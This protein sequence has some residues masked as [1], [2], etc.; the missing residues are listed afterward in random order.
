MSLVRQSGLVVAKGYRN[1]KRHSPDRS[2]WR[3]LGKKLFSALRVLYAVSDDMNCKQCGYKHLGPFGRSC[4]VYLDAVKKRHDL[5]APDTDWQLHVDSE[6]V[7]KLQAVE[8]PVSRDVLEK[9]VS[10]VS[11]CECQ[12]YISLNTIPAW[13]LQ[14]SPLFIMTSHSKARYSVM[15]NG[16][17]GAGTIR[18]IHYISSTFSNLLV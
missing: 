4:K 3:G 6:L 16:L 13:L 2:P 14:G 9:L 1:A 12:R 17:N 10:V 8:E 15:R 11:S 7:E 18:Y 5:Q